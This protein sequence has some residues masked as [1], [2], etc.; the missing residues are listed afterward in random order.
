MVG[1][2][3]NGYKDEEMLEKMEVG[4]DAKE[5]FTE[6][7]EYRKMQDRLWGQ[8]MHLDSPEA[9]KIMKELRNRY[10]KAIFH[11]ITEQNGFKSTFERIILSFA[12][13]PLD[14]NLILEKTHSL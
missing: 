14:H 5:C 4:K 3:W 7:G 2:I 10:C 6:M 8:M 1:S 12:C 13:A 9:K 11:E